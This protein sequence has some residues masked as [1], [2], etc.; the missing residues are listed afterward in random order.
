MNSAREP[1][2]T[3][4]EL[5]K[6]LQVSRNTALRIMREEGAVNVGSQLRWTTTKL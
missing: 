3:P 2:I 6:L 4:R 5:A 1:L